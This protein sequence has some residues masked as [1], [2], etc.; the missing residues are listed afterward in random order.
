MSMAN[1]MGNKRTWL[2][3][4]LMAGLGT[5]ATNAQA[6]DLDKLTLR[7]RLIDIMP[8]DKNSAD[9]TP[10]NT[11][12]VESK[13][14]P[15]IDFEYALTDHWALEL[16]LTVPQT[17]D[18]T[19]KVNGTSTDLGTV[20]HLPPTLTAKYY[21]GTKKVKPYVGAGLNFTWFTDNDLHL[22]STPLYIKRTSFGPAVQAGV[23]VALNARWS[24][25]AD[26]KKVWISTDVTLADGTLVTQVDVNPYIIGIGGGYRF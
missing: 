12:D 5:A 26:V 10:A 14:A 2:A 9:V 7:V 13:L 22:G 19:L 17:H 8:A 20:Q 15:D 1:R 18:V 4:L 23:D 6:F 25:S 11:V 3:A 21:F 16:L 24:L